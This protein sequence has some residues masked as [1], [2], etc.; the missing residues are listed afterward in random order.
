M[1]APRS[2]VPVAGVGVGRGFVGVAAGAVLLVTSASAE[3][4][5]SWAAV[6]VGAGVGA[7][8]D[9]APQAALAN[10]RKSKGNIRHN[11]RSGGLFRIDHS[12]VSGILGSHIDEN[13]APCQ[14]RVLCSFMVVKNIA[15]TCADGQS[16]TRVQAPQR[17]LRASQTCRP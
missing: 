2:A 3:R 12:F 10:S 14:C 4:A 9:V 7:G 11:R 13:R 8:V 17:G 6:G 15:Q 5:D 16:S 1:N